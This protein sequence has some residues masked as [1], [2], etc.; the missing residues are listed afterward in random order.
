MRY[1]IALI[2]ALSGCY[3]SKTVVQPTVCDGAQ[4]GEVCYSK[5]ELESY[6]YAGFCWNNVRDQAPHEAARESCLRIGAHESGLVTWKAG[7]ETDAELASLEALTT[8][9]VASPELTSAIRSSCETIA[10]DAAQC[11]STIAE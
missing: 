6:V 8:K 2:L 11:E 9:L 5:L 10:D 3:E 1:T 4:I 7:D